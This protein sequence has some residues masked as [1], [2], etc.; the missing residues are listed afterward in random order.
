MLVGVVRL[1]H[2]VDVVESGASFV[3]GAHNAAHTNPC[4]QPTRGQHHNCQWL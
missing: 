2:T 3:N 1:F 4:L